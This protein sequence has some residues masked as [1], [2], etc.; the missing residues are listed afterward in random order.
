MR[1]VPLRLR[2]RGI[3]MRLVLDDS[4][5]PLRV[6]RTLLKAVARA[7]RWSEELLSGRA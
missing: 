1:F 2:Q 3:E 5:P 7:Y 6:D 4:A